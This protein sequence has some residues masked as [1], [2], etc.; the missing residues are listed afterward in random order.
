MSVKQW[1]TTLNDDFNK[2]ANDMNKKIEVIKMPSPSLNWALSNGGFIEG[3]LAVMYGPESSGKSL[4]G[5]LTLIEIQKKYPSGICLLFDAEF[6]FNKD[7]FVKLG[8]D[9]KR[10]IVRQTNDPVQIFDYWYG[11]LLEHLQDGLPL[12]GIMLD[13]VKSILY[14]KDIKDVSTKMIQGGTGASYLPSVLKRITPIIRKYDILTIFIQ[15]V[16]EELDPYKKLANPYV[17]GD[18]RSLKHVADYFIEVTKIETKD[19][20]VL[21]GKDMLGKDFQVGHKV[22]MKVKKNRTGAPYRPAQF[23]LRYEKGIDNI[24]EEIYELAKSLGII[25]HPEGKS[26]QIWKFAEY[27][28][29]RGEANIKKWVIDNPN[30]QQEIVEAC[31]K[32]SKSQ[33]EK[34]IN[35]L[36]D[37]NDIEII[38]TEEE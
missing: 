16:Y 28:E 13:S 32:A 35:E 36:K 25:Y 29:I 4:L 11:E 12:K 14:P 33:V 7:W 9:P 37:E 5:L 34:R 27:E 24:E 30:I 22:R 2:I 17:F 3:K 8:G 23:T 15:Q 1:M 10:L 38:E 21:N 26:N 6:A 31:S 20:K 18:G 19:G